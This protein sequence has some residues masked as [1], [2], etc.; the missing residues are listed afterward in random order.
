MGAFAVFLASFAILAVKKPL[1]AKDAKDAKE[2]QGRF[3]G[4]YRAALNPVNMVIWVE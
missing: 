3:S 1:T 2:T 4:A